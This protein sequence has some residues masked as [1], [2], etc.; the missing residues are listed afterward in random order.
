M[1]YS[2]NLQLTVQRL[3]LLQLS[4]LLLSSLRT[5]PEGLLSSVGRTGMSH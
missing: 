4:I 2:N 5:T 3:T 1:L